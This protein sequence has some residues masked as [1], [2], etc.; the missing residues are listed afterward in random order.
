M[1]LTSKEREAVEKSIVMNEIM[2][3]LIETVRDKKDIEW[4]VEAIK[5]LSSINH[6]L[7][8]IL[9]KDREDT[10]GL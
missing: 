1:I 3:R 7:E 5:E 9:A 8:N 2:A 10:A 4:G 6:R